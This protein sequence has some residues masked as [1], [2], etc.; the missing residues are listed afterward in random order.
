MVGRN[1]RSA[2]S[3]MTVTARLAFSILQPVLMYYL[4]RTVKSSIT[5]KK[6]RENNAHA[7]GSF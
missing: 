4:L 5:F 7:K 6:P 3:F 2:G 1:A